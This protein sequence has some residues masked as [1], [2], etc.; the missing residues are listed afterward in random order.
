MKN[1]SALRN[2]FAWRLDDRARWRMTNAWE[3]RV[4]S[5]LSSAPKG[6]V[7]CHQRKARVIRHQT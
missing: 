5:H 7:I 2:D 6:A 3:R 1:D 4:P